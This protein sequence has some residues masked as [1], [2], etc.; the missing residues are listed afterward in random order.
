MTWPL[1]ESGAL[2]RVLR[3]AQGGGP[4]AGGQLHEGPGEEGGGEP[5]GDEAGGRY[6]GQ[7]ALTVDGAGLRVVACGRRSL[8][9]RAQAGDRAPGSVDGDRPALYLGGLTGRVEVAGGVEVE[10]MGSAACKAAPGG[11]STRVRPTPVSIA[12]RASR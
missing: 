4:V 1:T 12:R 9:V 3:E 6:H 10:V 7:E 5:I 8:I 2:A 11:G